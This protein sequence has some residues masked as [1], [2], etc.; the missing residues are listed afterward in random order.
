MSGDLRKPAMNI[1]LGSLSAIGIS[2]FLYIVFVFLLGAVCTRESLRYDFMIAEKVSL[3]G[4]LFLI[5]LYISSLASCMGGLYGAPR[6]LQCIAQEKVIPVLAFLGQGKGP[7]KTP[8]A[9]IC[10]T[11]LITMAFVFIGQVNILAPIV[12]I[13]FMLTYI[14]VDY[15]YFSDKPSCYGSGGIIQSRSNGTLLEF[16]KDMDQ[17][18]RPLSNE[19]GPSN[20]TTGKDPD[21]S[22]SV[23]QRKRKKA[24]K[25]M[26]QDS[27]LLDLDN[28][29]AAAQDL[30]REALESNDINTQSFS[31]TSYQGQEGASPFATMEATQNLSQDGNQHFNE[32]QNTPSQKTK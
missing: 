23:K 13:N 1:P 18:F 14:M 26:L 6:I 5:G 11:S 17:L 7:N 8:V 32:I 22:Q 24:A 31:E 28:N 12:T 16:T 19:P 4:F 3:V 2:W 10:L 27:F 21:T 30:C 9:A 20:E 29:T 15:S 25:Q